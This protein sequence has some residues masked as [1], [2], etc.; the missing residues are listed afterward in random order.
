MRDPHT[1]SNWD[2]YTALCLEYSEKQ[3]KNY[4]CGDGVDH[5]D[6]LWFRKAG[7]VLRTLSPEKDNT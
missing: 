6:K 5:Y 1:K 4:I 2:E 3:L 7:Q